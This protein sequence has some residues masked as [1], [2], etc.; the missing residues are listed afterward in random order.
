M[1]FR[2]IRT[3]TKYDGEDMQN[4]HP[5]AYRDETDEYGTP[6][7]AIEFEDLNKLMNFIKGIKIV[8]DYRENIPEI[9]IYDDWRE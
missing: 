8:I 3:S 9:E 4:P 7:W 6:L 2:I 5:L 1:K